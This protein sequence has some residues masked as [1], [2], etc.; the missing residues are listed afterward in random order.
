MPDSPA[1]RVRPRRPAITALHRVTASRRVIALRRIGAAALTATVAVGGALLMAPAAQAATGSIQTGTAPSAAVGTIDYAVYLPPN[2]DPAGSYPSVY[3]LHGRGDS[4][5][6]W[7]QVSTKLDALITEGAIPPLIAVRPDAPWSRR[8]NYY[9]DS[10]YTGAEPG[11]AVE[12]AF[13]QDLLA[14]IDATYATVDDRGARAIGGYSM[15]G[16]GA[17]RYATAHQDLFWLI[18]VEGVD[19]V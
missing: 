12:T 7:Q 17:L 4:M 19:G 6:A 18:P 11:A 1:A 2:Y 15:G 8:G 3:L 14:H 13:T 9:V 5:A 16:A 10:L